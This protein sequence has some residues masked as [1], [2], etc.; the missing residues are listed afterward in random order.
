MGSKRQRQGDLVTPHHAA[1]HGFPLQARLSK[2]LETS[3][4]L[5]IEKEVKACCY[6]HQLHDAFLQFGIH[7]KPILTDN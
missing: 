6:A 7:S 4:Q 5:R 1:A 3:Q 2:P